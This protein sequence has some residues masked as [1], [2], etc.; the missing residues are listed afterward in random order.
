MRS[1]ILTACAL[2]NAAIAA[3]Y[4]VCQ[5]TRSS[6]HSK[7]F[8]NSLPSLTSLFLSQ[9][10]LGISQVTGQVGTGYDP[11]RILPVG[12]FKQTNGHLLTISQ[13]VS[14]GTDPSNL[15]PHHPPLRFSSSLHQSW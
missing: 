4:R 2:V 7:A 9:V 8:L 15:S 10:T 6:S 1:F 13:L 3:D 5:S 14:F 12:K 11:N